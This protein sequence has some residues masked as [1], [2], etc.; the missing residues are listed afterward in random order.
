MLQGN[1]KQAWQGV[2]TMIS[3]PN[4]SQGK[5]NTNLTITD[6]K[7]GDLELANRLNNFFFTF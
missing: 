1:S 6:G 7:S 5:Y 3:V 4:K 2:R